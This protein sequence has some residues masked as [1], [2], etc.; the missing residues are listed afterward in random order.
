LRTG[1]A[2]TLSAL[3][4]VGFAPADEGRD[5]PLDRLEQLPETPVPT[6]L[7]ARDLDAALHLERRILDNLWYGQAIPVA[8]NLNPE[9]ERRLGDVARLFGYGDSA[10]WTGTYLASQSFRYHVATEHVGHLQA[11][12]RLRDRT[13]PLP[14]KGPTIPADLDEQ[15][16]FWTTQQQDAR[17]RVD[18]M[19]IKYHLLI[20]IAADWNEEFDPR[21]TDSETTF[22]GG[23]IGGELLRGYLQRACIP[24][25]APASHLWD[26]I[27]TNRR[28]FGPWTWEDGSEWYCENGTSRDA[29]AGTIFGLLI[30]FDLVGADDPE[31]QAQIRDDVLAMEDFLLRYA[32]S[33]PRAHGRISLPL[34]ADT[35]A[36][37][38]V[39]ENFISPLMQIQPPMRLAVVTAG[40]HVTAVA[41]T[42]EQAAGYR[43][44]Y[45]AEFASQAPMF[46]T[47]LFFDAADGQYNGYYAWNLNHL[48]AYNV[49][50]LAPPE[51]RP[52]LH[53]QMGGMDETTRDDVNA[54]FETISY[55]MTGETWRRD[56][57]TEHL[58]QWLDYRAAADAGTPVRNSQRCGIDLECVADDAFSYEVGDQEIP[59]FPGTATKQ[60]AAEPLPVALR[61]PTDFLWQR[62]PVQLDGGPEPWY[63]QNPGIDYLLPFWMLRYLE[64]EEPALNPFP[65]FPVA[66]S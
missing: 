31:L 58:A 22:G 42:A 44:I 6:G 48:H 51:Y 14:G 41:G 56:A 4:V 34:P 63:D 62:P 60:R 59:V 25:D 24:A 43:A 33:T 26:N 18:E 16:A 46:G 49:V 54:H 8:Y 28:V 2:V 13:K 9:R 50:R 61:P 47:A 53:A 3:L 21:V 66:V 11:L 27:G 19:V 10:L 38:H 15:L 64:V 39:F 65:P 52:V 17:R 23:V 7:A 57:A 40:M 12:Q 5:R 30:A 45:D 37:G 35:P 55:A 1:L 29:Y 32:W 20:N 36:T